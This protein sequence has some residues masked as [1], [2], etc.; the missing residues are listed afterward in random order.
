MDLVALDAA[1]PAETIAA[2]A[3]DPNGLTNA[4]TQVYVSQEKRRA[5]D[6]VTTAEAWW[7]YVGP[8][9]APPRMSRARVAEVYEVEVT[10]A[11][12][13]EAELKAWYRQLRAYF[14]GFRRPSGVERCDGATVGEAAYYADGPDRGVML[15]V[16]FHGRAELYVDQ[17]QAAV[18]QL[19]GLKVFLDPNRSGFLTTDSGNVT[20]LRDRS[21]NGQDGVNETGSNEPSTTTI[22]SRT[23]LD[24]QGSHGSAVE[25][26][27]LSD[28]TLF[29]EIHDTG[30]FFLALGLYIDGSNSQY[31]LSNKTGSAA[32]LG[33]N[34]NVYQDGG[35]VKL[36]MVVRD[37]AGTLM[38][39]T[40]TT[41]EVPTG[42]AVV[43]VVDGRDGSNVAF[44]VNG[45]ATSD[46]PGSISPDG[47]GSAAVGAAS[48][49]G[50]GDFPT[51]DNNTYDGKTAFLAYAGEAQTDVI[52][53]ALE[54]A[55]MAALGI[56]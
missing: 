12:A 55:A 16:T 41:T 42:E 3:N 38:S 44:R 28:T 10:K 46:S 23:W 35:T 14:D 53:D 20:R 34:L 8:E 40:E 45:S 37:G 29:E 18:E 50:K 15:R 31:L 6:A 11:S 1:L 22:G 5:G 32:G 48:L 27:A 7:R 2:V 13:T 25:Y 52:R 39:F 51:N 4:S 54:T 24:H 47:G 43:I 56:S 21:G 17:L 9:P 30:Q 19:R 49:G 26:L 33:F 36:L